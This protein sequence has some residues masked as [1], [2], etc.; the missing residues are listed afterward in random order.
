MLPGVTTANISTS[1]SMPVFKL[2]TASSVTEPSAPVSG[3]SSNSFASDLTI[4]RVP[5][6]RGDLEGPSTSGQNSGVPRLS[7]SD[8][9]D[10]RPLYMRGNQCREL[11]ISLNKNNELLMRKSSSVTLKNTSTIKGQNTKLISTAVK[12]QMEISTQGSAQNQQIE[13]SAQDVAQNQQMENCAQG[14]AQNR[15]V[16]NSAQGAQEDAQIN[17]QNRENEESA[18]EEVESPTYEGIS[19]DIEVFSYDEMFCLQCGRESSVACGIC[20]EALYC[21]KTCQETHWIT[22]HHKDCKSKDE[23]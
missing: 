1:G 21:S 14:V 13:D 5:P 19:G 15:Q 8:V 18:S 12:R 11:L 6:G 4:R 16:E 9:V 20:E 2:K 7:S 3:E 23:S 22:E 10:N 17:E